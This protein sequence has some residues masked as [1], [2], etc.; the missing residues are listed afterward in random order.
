MTT[1]T[2]SSTPPGPTFLTTKLTLCALLVHSPLAVST[3]TSLL[4]RWERRRNLNQACQEETPD[5]RYRQY[6]GQPPQCHTRNY[7]TKPARPANLLPGI[8]RRGLHQASH[9]LPA[10][11]GRRHRSGHHRRWHRPMYA[12][13]TSIEQ[14]WR[15]GLASP[16]AKATPGAYGNAPG[17]TSSTAPKPVPK[18]VPATRANFGP[19]AIVQTEKQ[20]AKRAGN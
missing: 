8:P 11:L 6:Y 16:T 17:A 20:P 5:A 4:I 7:P 1:S 13:Q 3:D 10:I 15:P 9:R 19:T 12:T 2:L 18:S 14:R